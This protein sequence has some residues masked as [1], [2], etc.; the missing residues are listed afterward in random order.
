MKRTAETVTYKPEHA[1]HCLEVEV[2]LPKHIQNLGALLNLLEDMLD[3]D[4]AH[5]KL[6]TKIAAMNL[7]ELPV[8][9]VVRFPASEQEKPESEGVSDPVARV[10]RILN[11]IKSGLLGYSIYEVDGAFRDSEEEPNSDYYSVRNRS[12]SRTVPLKRTAFM[13]ATPDLLQAFKSGEIEPLIQFVQQGSLTFEEGDLTR[14]RPR[15]SGD[16]RQ[17]SVDG[18]TYW[19]DSDGEGLSVTK[20]L[21]LFEERTL[22]IR[23]LIDLERIEKETITVGANG[24]QTSVDRI[25]GALLIIG[26]FLVSELGDSVGIE[27][28]I[29]IYYDVGYLWKWHRG[30][31]SSSSPRKGVAHPVSLLTDGGG[32][33]S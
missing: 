22:V 5:S 27:D 4:R 21:K 30:K 15:P 20:C 32:S 31:P 1:T 12:P 8:Q 6:L 24:L 16:T 7:L 19:F 11:E 33:I 10:T 13:S 17:V 23:F 29:W 26:H 3:P 18:T 9:Q 25:I 28:Y 14:N 2:Y